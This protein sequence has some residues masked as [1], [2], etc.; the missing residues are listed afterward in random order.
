LKLFL[1]ETRSLPAEIGR[2]GES[3]I[4]FFRSGELRSNEI[5]YADRELEE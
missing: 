5:N 2:V 3:T 1:Y 4:E